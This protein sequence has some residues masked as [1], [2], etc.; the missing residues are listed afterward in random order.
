MFE[1]PREHE[2]T[3]ALIIS[4]GNAPTDHPIHLHGHDFYILAQ[5]KGLWNGGKATWNDSLANLNN[6]PRRDTAML[7]AGLSYLLL[8]WK[9][10]NPGFWLMHCHLG[11]HTSMGFD[12]Q[13]LEKRQDLAKMDTRT[14]NET[15]DAWHKHSSRFGVWQSESWDQA[16]V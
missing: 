10:D 12:W 6:P 3:Y 14:L 11:W 2:W 15:C 5:G 8:A 1:T 7:Y 16:G 4:S 9:A 13:F